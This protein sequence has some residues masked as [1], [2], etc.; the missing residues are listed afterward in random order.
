MRLSEAA[1]LP[2]TAETSCDAWQEM[3]EFSWVFARSE[4]R[5]RDSLSL[6]AHY[7]PLRT[8]ADDSECSAVKLKSKQEE[9]FE[10]EKEVRFP[11]PIRAS[12]RTLP[13]ISC[14]HI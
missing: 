1:T 3:P 14:P 7:T 2:A 4:V 13:N 5:R 6:L 12:P 9:I 11:K 10:V 8:M